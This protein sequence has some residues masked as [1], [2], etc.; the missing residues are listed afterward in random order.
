MLGLQHD[1]HR[2]NFGTSNLGFGDLDRYSG[3][4]VKFFKFSLVRSAVMLSLGLG[5]SRDCSRSVRPR[6]CA[7]KCSEEVLPGEL[8]PSRPCLIIQNPA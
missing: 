1:V 6:R 2:K 7:L 3:E 4:I 5:T 8:I